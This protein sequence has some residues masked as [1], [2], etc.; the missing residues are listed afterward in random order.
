VVEL[1][2][3]AAET[4]SAGAPAGADRLTAPQRY[5]ASVKALKVVLNPIVVVSERK[6]NEG[7]GKALL[8]RIAYWALL[9]PKI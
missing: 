2:L 3:S 9:F 5:S 7:E 1:E 4:A 8:R 6:A